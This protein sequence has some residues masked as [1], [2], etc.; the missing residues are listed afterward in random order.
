MKQEG[1]PE[2]G[3]CYSLTL[4]AGLSHPLR[5]THRN[6]QFPCAI[7]TF[8]NRFGHA[9]K[10]V[11]MPVSEAD[12][13][14]LVPKPGAKRRRGRRLPKWL[15]EDD[16]RALL[17]RPSRR[18]PTGVRN[19]AII[20]VMLLG[21]LRCTEALTLRPRD[22][23]LRDYLIRVRGKGDK[24]RVVPIEPAL[25]RDLLAWRS[26]RPPGPTFFT[27]LKGGRV[28]DGYV[29]EMIARYGLKAGI[30]RRVH[31]HLLRHTAASCWLNE[32]NLSL[33]EVQVLLGHARI[34]TTELYLHASVPDIA[35]KMR[36][37]A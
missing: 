25:E 23:D 32:K 11:S 18:Y 3:S 26:I 19:R 10:P 27:T 1:R 13:H 12:P 30:G 17:S 33:R 31:P 5:I 2:I 4:S 29:R 8:E 34:A 20:S 36:G 15:N 35:R 9:D 7:H 22:V 28:D 14:E 37:W 24:E 21:G 6:R 16:R